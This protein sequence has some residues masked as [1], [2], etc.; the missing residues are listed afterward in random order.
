MQPFSFGHVLLEV[1]EETLVVRGDDELKVGK[2][3]RE[4][5]GNGLP[6]SRVIPR[7]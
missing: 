4:N 2:L 5:G 3:L 6:V 7:L 1:V